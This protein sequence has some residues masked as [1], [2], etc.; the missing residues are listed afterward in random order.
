MK[1]LEYFKKKNTA[2]TAKERLKIIIS[3]ERKNQKSDYIQKMR[4]DI[5]NVIK[6]YINIEE[7]K[8]LVNLDQCDTNSHISILELSVST[9]SNADNQ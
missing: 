6:K 5:I 3:H 4:Q 8:I 7:K 1:V 9:P 2:N